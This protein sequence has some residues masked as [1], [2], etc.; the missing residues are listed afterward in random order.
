MTSEADHM[1]AEFAKIGPEGVRKALGLKQYGEP[2]KDY[3]EQWLLHHESLEAA[4]DRRKAI[5]VAEAANELALSANALAKEA[6]E[7]AH[8][9]ASA[10]QA[11]NTLAEGANRISADLAA[12]Q[13]T[14]NRI[15][16]AAAVISAIALAVSVA[17]AIW[18]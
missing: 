9:A 16:L 7:S 13:A 8:K 2:R 15:A 10:A 5:D 11:A 12:R 3:A 4:R 17:V 18:K 1:W 14:Y 6:N